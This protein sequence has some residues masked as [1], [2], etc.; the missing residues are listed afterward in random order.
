MLTL[1]LA[2]LSALWTPRAD[3]QWTVTFNVDQPQATAVLGAQ[4][5]GK[6]NE[7]LDRVKAKLEQILSGAPGARR[8]P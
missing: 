4:R 7:A 5:V 6:M 8:S 1:A 2:M 3:A